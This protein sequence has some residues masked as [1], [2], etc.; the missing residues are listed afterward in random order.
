MAL[1]SYEITVKTHQ[2][3]QI[4]SASFKT[5]SLFDFMYNRLSARGIK[6][7]WV[8]ELKFKVSKSK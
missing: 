5:S 8:G 3:A 7:L 4:Q 6:A 2:S 1:E